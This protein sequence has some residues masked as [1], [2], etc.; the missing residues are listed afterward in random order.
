[1]SSLLEPECRDHDPEGKF[2]RSEFKTLTE[3]SVQFRECRDHDPE[4]R[5]SRSKF[6]TLIEHSVQ[7]NHGTLQDVNDTEIPGT[8]QAQRK[9]REQPD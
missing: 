1:M 7:F 5:F 4:G 2:S 6:K 9:L 8:H 3:H